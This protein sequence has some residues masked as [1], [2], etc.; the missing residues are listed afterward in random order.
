MT[1]TPET[2]TEN[3]FAKLNLSLDVL[4]RRFDGYHEIDSLFVTIDLHDVVSFRR[5]DDDADVVQMRWVGAADGPLPS[6]AENLVTLA[7]RRLRELA[8]VQ[9]GTSIRVDKAIPIGAGLGGG[10]SDAAA[11]LRGLNHLW[12]LGMD[13]V[14][15]AAVGAEIGSDVPF[16][17]TGGAA[18][19]RGRGE[20]V[21]PLPR[22]PRYWFVLGI[23]DP[24][25]PTSQVYAN[26]GGK[27][28]STT[29]DAVAAFASGDVDALAAC[30]SNDLEDAAVG[31]RP[32]LGA[33]ASALRRAGAVGVGLS[34]SGPT[35][36]G[37]ARDEAHARTVAAS[38]APSPPPSPPPPS[39]SSPFA[40]VE[41]VAA[42]LPAPTTVGY[43]C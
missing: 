21:D 36:F 25:L 12:G 41:V 23:S 22:V 3:A 4:G 39:P 2:H 40:R 30:L 10:S 7:A 27:G 28:R 42:T 34:G 35:W 1:H 20:V 37:L 11:C 31:L 32:S 13:P 6:P 38:V 43:R 5:R 19:V 26:F 9:P 8:P 24:P 15:L 29:T 33:G 14:E 18:R 17:L 16:L